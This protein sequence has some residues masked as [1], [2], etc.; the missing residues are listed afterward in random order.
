M[1]NHKGVVPGHGVGGR[2]GEYDPGRIPG[3][4]SGPGDVRVSIVDAAASIIGDELFVFEVG[5]DGIDNRIWPV[6]RRSAVA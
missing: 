2:S 5:A 6:P 1:P 4:E 3:G